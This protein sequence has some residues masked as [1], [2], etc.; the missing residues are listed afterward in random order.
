MKTT[1]PTIEHHNRWTAERIANAILEEFDD[2]RRRFDDATLGLPHWDL[3][4]TRAFFIDATHAATSANR[5]DFPDKL[6]AMMA[7]GETLIRTAAA[8]RCMADEMRSETPT[9]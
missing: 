7:T 5:D 6:R 4:Q 1:R 9:Q 2:A 3:E 8:L